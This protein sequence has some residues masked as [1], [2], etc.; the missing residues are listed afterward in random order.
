MSI[1]KRK[2]KNKFCSNGHNKDIVGREKTGY[3]R[4]C[5]RNANKKSYQKHKKER[6]AKNKRW[7][8]IN[9]KKCNLKQKKYY[10]KNKIA[11]LRKNKEYERKN[12]AKI[13]AR[14]KKYLKRK[15]KVDFSFKL[16][17]YLR[18]RLTKAIRNNW[19]VGSAVQ[20]LGCTIEFLK[21]YI[22]SKFYGK[23][24]WK[25]WGKCWELDHIKPLKK[26]NL[27]SRK[28]FL[29]AVHYTNLQ[30]LTISDH[31]KKTYK[32]RQI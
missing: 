20:D 3:C 1:K 21:D 22:T 19:K 7:K 8:K 18:A 11:I 26:F 5:Q 10:L 6:L 12:R 15:R 23:M 32:E 16:V 24:T 31:R 4:K 25:N 13:N 14:K 30:P 2:T 9:R 29:K 28:Q 27:T 17:S